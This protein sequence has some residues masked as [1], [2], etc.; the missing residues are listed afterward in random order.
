MTV[1]LTEG[2]IEALTKGSE[3]TNPLLQILNIRYIEVGSGADRLRV[4]MSDGLHYMSSFLLATQ[5]NS[6]YEENHLAPYCVCMLK[7]SFTNTLKDGRRVV[8]VLDLEVVRS[9]GEVGGK[10]GTP[11]PYVEGQ[12]VSPQNQNPGQS[13]PAAASSSPHSRPRGSSSTRGPAGKKAPK[14]VPTT[15]GGSKANVVPIASLNPYN[16]KW[17][18]RVRVTNKSSIRTWSNSRGE[19]KLFSFETV[20]ESGEIKVTAFNKEV[21]KFFPLLET[22]KVYYI[23]RGKLKVANKQYSTLKNDYEMTLHSETSILPCTDDQGLPMVQCDFVPISQLEHRDKDAIIDVIGVCRSVED[24]S[25]LTTKTSREVSKRDIHLMD[26]SAKMVT[27][28]LW[29]E[30]AERFDGS[31]QPV[32][33]VKGARVSDFR[34][35]SLSALFSSTVMVNPD[36]PEAYRLRGWFD[37]EGYALAGQSLTEM[38]SRGG[39]ANTCWKTLSDVTTEQLGQGDKADYYTCVAT[40]L[41][42]RKESC[43]YQACPMAHCQKKVVDQHNGLYRCEKCDKEFPNYKHRLIL[44]ANIADFGDNQWVTCFQETA[45]IILCHDAESLGR[46]KDTNEDAFDEVFHKANFTTHIFRNRVKL[47][48]YN[49]ETRVKTTVMDVKP[50]NHREYSRRLISSIRKMAI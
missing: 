43:V 7:K 6:L 17:T 23:T 26:S 36:I 2:A 29:G 32:V 45:E 20:D 8:V 9:A 4:M 3:V 33:A 25:R 24:V 11:T 38:R 13:L 30:E 14:A 44:S 49:E 48:T 47:E 31:C 41:F 34:G 46:L 15:P 1:K 19:G 16:T 18:V 39:G 10:I 40:V 35:R 42:C 22:G 28:T 21:D 12:S 5:L 27:V 37:K 50:V